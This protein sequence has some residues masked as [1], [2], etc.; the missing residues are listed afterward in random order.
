LSAGF[1]SALGAK[2]LDVA[3]PV[4]KEN[5]AEVPAEGWPN[6]DA[7]EA[8]DAKLKPP[9][10]LDNSGFP[11]S[12]IAVLLVGL[13]S[14]MII[15]SSFFGGVTAL[16]VPA[17]SATV[18]EP[19]RMEPDAGAG[20]DGAAGVPNTNGFGA[21]VVGVEGA[22]PNVNG[23]L[24]ASRAGEAGSCPKLKGAA[25]APNRG[26]GASTVGAEA[27]RAEEVAFEL[28]AAGWPKL[29]DGFGG[30]LAPGLGVADDTPKRVG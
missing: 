19:N 11:L 25:L 22:V 27:D 16:L 13:S 4:P 9:F 1:A 5:G 7:G 12:S 23:S 8:V 18:V 14:I 6:G 3:E 2:G 29:K 30:S 10:S 20:V 17:S 26:L 24:A 28:A 15:E 21:S